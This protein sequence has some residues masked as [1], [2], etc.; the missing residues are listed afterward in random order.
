MD[1]YSFKLVTLGGEYLEF[2]FERQETAPDRDGVFYLFKLTDL[3]KD[4]GDRLLSVYRGGPKEFYGT[5]YD[6]RVHNVCLNVLRRAVDSGLV[7]FDVPYEKHKYQELA[8]SAA[9]FRARTA[10]G[11]PELR[12]YFVHK[13]YW[14][15]YREGLVGT[16]FL[17]KFDEELDLDYLGV[18]AEDVRRG[19]WLLRERGLLDE[20]RFPGVSLPTAKLVEIYEAKQSTTLPSETVFPKGTQYEAFK[21]V[22]AILRSATREIVIADNYMNDEVLDM[23]LAIPS[24]P[25]IRLLTFKPA[26]DFKVAV[27]RFQ[28]QY[29]RVV[30][31]RTHSAEI[32]DRAIVVDDTQ[33]YALGGSIKDMGTKLTFLNKVEDATNISKLRA[34]LDR[35]WAAGVPLH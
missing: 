9:D 35:I 28:A 30:E 7:S 18:K 4:R 3:A 16:K 32:H 25:N 21:K 29:Q 6:A 11:D 15:G 34:E 31:A 33:F 13:A 24:Q 5:D 19:V 14:L 2:Q 1:S 20:K 23:L 10:V 27:K 22:S 8:L 17:I 26:P 12:Q